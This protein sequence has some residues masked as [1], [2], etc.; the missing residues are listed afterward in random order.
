MHRMHARPLYAPADAH[1]G[2]HVHAASNGIDVCPASAASATRTA[3]TA[4]AAH[5]TRDEQ[6]TA[7]PV[8]GVCHRCILRWEGPERLRD[9]CRHRRQRACPAAVLLYFAAHI[10]LVRLRPRHDTATAVRLDKRLRAWRH[11][12][13]EAFA[14]LLPVARILVWRHARQLDNCH[15]E[16]SAILSMP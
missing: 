12:T 15:L 5:A 14:P 4:S 2:A 1:R 7:H 13:W 9:Y 8:G 10:V 11:T 6:P 16:S 3:S